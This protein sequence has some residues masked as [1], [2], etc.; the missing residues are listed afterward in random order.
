MANKTALN[1]FFWVLGLL[2]SIL[3]PLIATLLYFPVWSVRGGAASISGIVFLLLFLSFLPFF[4]II[5]ERLRSPS[6][7]TVWLILFICFF[8]LSRIAD[9]VTVISFFGFIGNL[10]GSVF[11][12]LSA[13]NPKKETE[14]EG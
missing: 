6:A 14:N 5:K 1:R 7:Y 9:E 10:L 3:P 8:L 12:R 11:F 13:R 4:N 2:F